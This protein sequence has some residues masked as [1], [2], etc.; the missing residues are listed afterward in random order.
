MT[1][2]RILCVDDERNILDAFRRQLRG[3]FELDVF[4]APATALDHVRGGARYAVVLSDMRMPG[5]DGATF[6]RSM[7]ELNPLAVRVMLTGN[8]EQSTAAQ[9]INEGQI[10]RFLTKPCS[11]SD[12]EEV[13]GAAVKHHRLLTA[14]KD[15]LQN[16][17]S[18]SVKLLSDLLALAD[19][20]AYGQGVALR[21]SVRYYAAKLN[22]PAPWEVELA[23]MLLGIGWVAVPERVRE[24]A[25]RGEKLTLEET[26]IVESVPESGRALLQ[27]IP[28]LEGVARIV[29]YAQ[30]N[31]DGSTTPH[32]GVKGRDLP[33]AARLIRIVSD[34]PPH[35]G[36][37]IGQHGALQKMLAQSNRYDTEMIRS[38]LREGDPQREIVA[39]PITVKARDLCVGQ[40]LMDSLYCTDG[41]LLLRSGTY[42][43]EL[44]IR[45]IR[46]YAEAPGLREPILVDC[47]IPTRS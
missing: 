2:E 8:A 36:T 12:L 13:L 47:R 38:L 39:A 22:L 29:H 33:A 3:K 46:N 19:P 35:D 7:Q 26:K 24:R 1:I 10:F 17:L 20:A 37:G 30:Q 16:T 5:M 6:L 43:S 4:T 31:Y 9:A 18:G 15:L 14:E 44:L 28:R 40:R 27:N 32:D 25:R 42:L 34:L 23:T 45:S 11:S 41:R 21:E